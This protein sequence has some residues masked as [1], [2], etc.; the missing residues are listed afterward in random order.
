MSTRR[1][2]L[3][4]IMR[5]HKLTSRKVAELVGVSQSSVLQWMC[6]ARPTP[7][8]ALIILQGLDRD[9]SRNG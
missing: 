3:R 5:A 6:G 4:R 1:V 7:K 2:M 9:V 8:Y